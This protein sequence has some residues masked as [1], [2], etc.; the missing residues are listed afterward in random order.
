MLREIHPEVKEKEEVWSKG[1]SESVMGKWLK[2][3]AGAD[4]CLSRSFTEWRYPLAHPS[5]WTSLKSVFSS[6]KNLT[7][8]HKT[9]WYKLRYP[10]AG[11]GQAGSFSFGASFLHRCNLWRLFLS[12]RP[13]FS[14]A[15]LPSQWLPP[16]HFHFVLWNAPSQLRLAKSALQPTAYLCCWYCS[17]CLPGYRPCCKSPVETVW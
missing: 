17:E 14:S 8:T 15:V 7:L 11:R 10:R 6:F 2:S 1:W 13:T 4:A 3:E 12:L 9:Q 5:S 16:D